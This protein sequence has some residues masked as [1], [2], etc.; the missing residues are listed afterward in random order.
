[1]KIVLL[2]ALTFGATD[3]TAFEALGQVEIYQTTSAEQT[4][5][6]ITD[7]D[8]IVTNKVVI[9]DFH[10]PKCKNLKL[11]CVAATGMNNVDLEAAK[12][13][14]IE[15][16]N[17]AGY[18]TDSVIQHTFSMLFF[19]LGHSRYYDVYVKDGTYAKSQIFTD[20][21]KPFFEIKGK[22][23]GIIGLGS[24]GR[25]VAK[26]AK[27]FGAEILYYSTSG[28]SREEEYARVEL[29]VLLQTCDIISI[30]A[31][32]NEKT[33][34]LLDYEQLLMCK[35]GATLLN[36]GR[37]GIINEDAI[38]KIVDEKNIYFALDVLTQEPMQETSPL[39]S[40]K[41]KENLYITPHIAWASVEARERLIALT[42]EN[43][44]S[45]S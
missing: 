11:I 43:I 27:T 30:H 29:D 36:L 24:I 9:R 16:K 41:R 39:L 12:K 2:D 20:V 44:K 15:V 26:V 19:L 18:S 32:L 1:M 13:Y 31:P 14:N 33:K 4:L 10:M 35:E 25:G 37:G 8:V 21:S 28:V 40:V 42:I 45:L 7:A 5:E 38:A 6:R 34:N 23:W 17:V 3:L 22:K